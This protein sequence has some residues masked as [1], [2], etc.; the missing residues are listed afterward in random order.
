MEFLRFSLGVKTVPSKYR[1]WRPSGRKNGQRW[2]DLEGPNV[3]TVEI[4]PPDDETRESGA[5]TEDANTM[6]PVWFQVPP[7]P[8]EASQITNAGPLVGS[9]FFSFPPAKK[10]MNRLSGDQNG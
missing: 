3:V 5:F 2:V 6:S 9:I 10:P 8:S 1:K 4:P 7:R